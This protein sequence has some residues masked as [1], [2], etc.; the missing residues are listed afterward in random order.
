MANAHIRVERIPGAEL[1][2][3]QIEQLMNFG[4]REAG[5]IDEM[6]AAARL[7]DQNL[8]MQIVQE[9]VRMEDEARQVAE[10]K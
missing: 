5:L 9:L 3:H 4:R 6:T 2:D 8:V 7:G 1:T 10:G